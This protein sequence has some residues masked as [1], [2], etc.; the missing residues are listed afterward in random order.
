MS[1]VSNQLCVNDRMVFEEKA[2]T[3]SQILSW[4]DA[5]LMHKPA[6]VV[7]F[8]VLLFFLVLFWIYF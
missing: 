3:Q 8:F 2:R 4:I 5:T 6:Y 7:V 1:H